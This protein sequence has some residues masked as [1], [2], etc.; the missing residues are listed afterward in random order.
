MQ[1]MSEETFVCKCFSKGC[2]K[3]IGGVRWRSINTPRHHRARD[4]LINQTWG[5][6][7]NHTF[8][9][10]SEEVQELSADALR[11]AIA[12]SQGNENSQAASEGDVDNEEVQKNKTL[13]TICQ[14]QKSLMIQLLRCFRSLASS[15]TTLGVQ[16]CLH[17][18]LS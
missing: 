10:H 1:I 13:Q 14:T 16:L 4:L 8:I 9:G 5:F 11:A 6:P 15:R 18:W 7:S 12:N 3:Q 17:G 2:G